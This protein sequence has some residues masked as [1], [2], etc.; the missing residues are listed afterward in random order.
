MTCKS[1]NNGILAQLDN[2][3]LNHFTIKPMRAFYGI[4]NKRGRTVEYA[5][6]NNIRINKIENVTHLTIPCKVKHTHK[7]EKPKESTIKFKDSQR[8]F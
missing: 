8:K 5:S 1:C 7:H 6:S 2:Y 4:A 3:L